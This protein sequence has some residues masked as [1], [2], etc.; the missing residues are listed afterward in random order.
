MTLHAYVRDNADVI[1]KYF[2][3]LIA[4]PISFNGKK[5]F[6]KNKRDSKSIKLEQNLYSM[7]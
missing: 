6:R 3:Q 7:F 2:A 4:T 1:F 5:V